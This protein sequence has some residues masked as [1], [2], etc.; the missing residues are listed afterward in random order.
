M[1]AV[2]MV[3]NMPTIIPNMRFM[4][5]SPGARVSISWSN[6]F[7]A[8][9]VPQPRWSC[10]GLDGLV[11]WIGHHQAQVGTLPPQPL[12]CREKFIER[13]PLHRGGLA[14]VVKKNVLAAE[15]TGDDPPA[16]ASLFLARHFFEPLKGR[17]LDIQFCRPN[18]DS[19]LD[20]GFDGIHGVL[21]RESVLS[22]VALVGNID[23]SHHLPFLGVK[24]G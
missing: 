13:L 8:A 16:A 6:E 22:I 19:N 1:K 20:S 15:L 4:A 9:H 24:M 10:C 14:V 18:P 3:S 2:P 17:A 5:A 21:W 12:G 7:L 23:R 11:R